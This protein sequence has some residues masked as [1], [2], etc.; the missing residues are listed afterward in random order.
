MLKLLSPLLAAILFFSIVSQV[1]AS[2]LT[3]L[4]GGDFNCKSGQGKTTMQTISSM[5]LP[6]LPLGDYGYDKV[7]CWISLTTGIENDGNLLK[8][9]IGNHDKKDLAALV[10]FCG[11]GRSDGA[12]YQKIDNVAFVGINANKDWKKGSSQYTFID[13]SLSDASKDPSIKWIVVN[14]HHLFVTFKVGGGHPAEK[15]YLKTYQPLFEKYGVDVVN[16]AHNHVTGVKLSTD[17]KV[18]TFTI[19]GT[20]GELGDKISSSDTKGWKGVSV[21]KGFGME[22]FTDT[23]IILHFMNQKG[24]ERNCSTPEIGQ[25]RFIISGNATEPEPQIK[26]IN[27]PVQTVNGTVLF[28][29]NTGLPYTTMMTAKGNASIPIYANITR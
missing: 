26:I 4:A 12:F 17:P 15:D 6:F 29:D 1:N 2:N 14:T 13:E 28:M 7:A 9:V 18:P 24:Q 27:V 21:D 8:C 22:E 11:N 25:C 5:G 23:Q 10:S 16:Q 20:G 19:L 3:I